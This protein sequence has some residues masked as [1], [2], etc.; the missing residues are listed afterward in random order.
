[1]LF[2]PNCIWTSNFIVFFKAWMTMKNEAK[3][4]L[5]EMCSHKLYESA[6]FSV[7]FWSCTNWLHWYLILPQSNQLIF[8]HSCDFSKAQGFCY[9][10][11]VLFSY[12]NTKDKKYESLSSVR[13]LVKD[14][15][16]QE[17]QQICHKEPAAVPEQN[18]HCT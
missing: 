11:W 3:S 8:C 16:H 14:Q 6:L 15:S 1:M 5:S 7:L 17:L 9:D 18:P 2:F 4:S 12:W 10:W 13:Y